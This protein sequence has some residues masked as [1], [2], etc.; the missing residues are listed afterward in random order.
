MPYDPFRFYNAPTPAP[1][2]FAGTLPAVDIVADEYQQY[3]YYSGLTNEEKKF[4]GSN[5]P[6][7]RAVRAKAQ[8][9]KVGQTY[10]DLSR[11]AKTF[12]RFG[13][14]MTGIPGSIRFSRNPSEN[15][16]GAL[17]TFE[18]TIIGSAP[19]IPQGAVPYDSKEVEGLFNTLDAA[20]GAVNSSSSIKNGAYCIKSYSCISFEECL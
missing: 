1:T 17:R 2:Y 12:E 5:T 3:P 6:I 11:V 15:L 14:E 16:G 19:G 7:G 4:F 10:N 8:T 20:R 13:A 18:K 9:G